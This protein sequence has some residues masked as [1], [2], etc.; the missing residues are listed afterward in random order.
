MPIKRK[1]GKFASHVRQVQL[2]G[3]IAR[4]CSRV[5]EAE[6]VWDASNLSAYLRTVVPEPLWPEVETITP[7][8]H[9]CLIRL[10]KFPYHN[11]D[12]GE[13]QLTYDHVAVILAMTLQGG[14][15]YFEGDESFEHDDAWHL[16]FKCLLFQCLSV[17]A[18]ESGVGVE[19]SARTD[20][21]DEDLIRAHGFVEQTSKARHPDDPKC[22][23]ISAAWFRSAEFAALVKL[24]LYVEAGEDVELGQLDKQVDHVLDATSQP[25]TGSNEAS[26][27]DWG[28]FQS[29]A[30]AKPMLFSQ[31]EYLLSPA[32]EKPN[33]EK[34][35]PRENAP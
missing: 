16:L 15:L 13:E 10:G 28:A 19:P 21:D 32:A 34:R 5:T 18:D 12:P 11:V 23:G 20:A 4:L 1:G 26:G 35:T 3:G 17:T 9:R 22:H 30:V 14:E 27:V 31:L 33:L 6:A 7:I 25:D 29:V 2:D 24:L 8:L